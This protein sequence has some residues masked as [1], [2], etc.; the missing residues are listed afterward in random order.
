MQTVEAESQRAEP[1]ASPQSITPTTFLSSSP[2]RPRG[3]FSSPLQNP[4][5]NPSFRTPPRPHMASS[6]QSG[7]A[8]GGGTITSNPRVWIVAGIAVAGVIVL[9]EVARRRRRWLR[10]MS[11]TPPDAGAFCDR[12]ELHPQ[13]Q[14]PPPA[15]RPILSGLTFAASDK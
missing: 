10:G 4:S 9:A 3:C 12:F 2:L 6:S 1:S 7:G 8:G 15:A 13:P 11:G 5:L 14:P